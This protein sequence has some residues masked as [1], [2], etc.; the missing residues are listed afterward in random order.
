MYTNSD[1]GGQPRNIFLVRITGR[2]WEKIRDIFLRIRR[3]FNHHCVIRSKACRE[4]SNSNIRYSVGMMLMIIGVI[5]NTIVLYVYK[6]RFRRSTSRIFI[7]SLAVFDL[8]TCL[9]GMPFHIMDMLY[10]YMFVWD[11][12]HY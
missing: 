12:A 4:I 7:L 5:G 6:F 8:I 10:P 11:A 9:L 2:N 1:L 3:I